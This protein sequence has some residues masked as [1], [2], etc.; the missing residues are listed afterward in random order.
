MLLFWTSEQLN[1]T[2]LKKP[3]GFNDT[4]FDLIIF[5]DFLT[6][7]GHLCCS[8]LLIEVLFQQCE[9]LHV[10]IQKCLH[11]L[12]SSNP[13]IAVYL[14][15]CFWNTEKQNNPSGNYV[16]RAFLQLFSTTNSF[17][18]LTIYCQDYSCQ[19]NHTCLQMHTK[20]SYFFFNFRKQ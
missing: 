9:V 6:L 7:R 12:R 4:A 1:I 2:T 17:S 18:I 14:C 15:Y 13:R 16:K 20:D 19:T 8:K 11:H 5:V 10:K 3:S